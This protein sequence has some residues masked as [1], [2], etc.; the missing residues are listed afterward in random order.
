MTDEQDQPNTIHLTD[1][2]AMR[3]LSH[4]TRLRLLGELRMRGPQTV[5]MLGEIVDEA[6]GSVSYHL[7]RLAAFGFVEE[8]PELAKDRRETW[9]ASV[10]TTTSWKPLELLADPQRHAASDVLRRQIYRSYLSSLENYL[11]IEPA[12][13]PEWVAGA[14][15]GDVLLDLTAAELAELRDE[16]T[17][18][19]DRWKARSDARTPGSGDEVHGVSLIFHAFRRQV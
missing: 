6:P 10:H 8:R 2:R 13:E 4:A 3:V 15:G 18:L 16:V 17:A 5:G 7:G 12:L 19:A 1:P 14:A 11:E 9:W